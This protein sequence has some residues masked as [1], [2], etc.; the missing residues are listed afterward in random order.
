MSSDYLKIR[1][2]NYM[3]LNLY[4]DGVYN[5]DLADGSLVDLKQL[6]TERAKAH[7]D[8]ILGGGLD[9]DE[10]QIDYGFNLFSPEQVCCVSEKANVFDLKIVC[11]AKMVDNLQ[12]YNTGFFIYPNKELVN[13]PLRLVNGC[14]PK[15]QR[16]R[17]SL[18]VALDC[19]EVH[20]FKGGSE[21]WYLIEKG[22]SFLQICAPGLVPFFVEIRGQS[23]PD[24]NE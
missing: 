1:Y 17:E 4:V 6:Y 15:W 12:E 14:E 16:G 5:V 11:S 10:D 3:L 22:D 8:K 2:N 24:R 7:N 20:P 13:T 21:G 23:P 18:T 19:K 9:G